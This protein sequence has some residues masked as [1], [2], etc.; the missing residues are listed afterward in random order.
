MLSVCP[1]LIKMDLVSLHVLTSML[2]SA[3][4]MGATI[5]VLFCVVN[6]FSL[7]PEGSIRIIWVSIFYYFFFVVISFAAASFLLSI[8]GHL[9]VGVSALLETALIHL[10]YGV[11]VLV[12]Y[13]K[14]LIS[15]K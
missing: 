7:K 15:R 12:L 13:S 8:S 1:R 14:V 10:C 4:Q 9:V 2:S 6:Y 11:L 3:T 5:L